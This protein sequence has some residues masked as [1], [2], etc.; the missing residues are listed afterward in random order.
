MRSIRVSI[1]RGGTFTDVYAEMTTPNG[2]DVQVIK[3]LSEDPA[4]YP[5]A[6]REGIRR[7]LELF[8]GV[9]H[10]RGQPVDTSRLEYIRMGT[11][12][13]TN[14]LLE[15]NG[16]RTALVITKGFKD[17]LYIGNQSRPKIFD[18]EITTPDML[19]EDVVEVSER[20]QLVYG[21]ARE[22]TDIQGISGDYVRVLEPP[23]VTEL[24]QQLQA[25]RTKGI[26]SIA[27]V[28]T[29]SYTFPRH[30]QAI[31]AI[32]KELGFTQISLS[33]EIM[34]MIKMVP[35]GFTSCADA[36]LT[37]VI[38]D[39][40][41]SFC[42]GF[43]AGLANVKISFMQ[44]DGGL[45]PMASFCGN[46]AILS[47]PAGG[48]V[49]YAR[50]T[51]PPTHG[52]HAQSSL[53]VIGFDMGG[54][55]TD[56]S[57]FDGN[58]DHVFESVTAN[59]PIRAPQLDIQTVAAGGGSRLFYKNNMFV[60]GPESVRAHPGPVCYRKNGYLSVTDANL[61]TGRILPKY[62]P[63]I[64]GPH[65]N[66]PLDLDGAR[67]AFEALTA[68]INASQSVTYSVEEVA[69]GFLR[70]ANEAMC[71]PIR[72]LTQMRGYDIST[73][74]L[75]CFGGAGP[76]HACAIAKALGMTK[77]YVQRYSGIL[78][79]YG[80]SLAD[81][82]I[83]KQLPASS[84]YSA[85]AKPSVV[86]NLL[87]LANV[88]RSDLKAEGFDEAFC[89]L[90]YYLNLRYE[91]TDTALMTRCLVTNP[92]A[93]ITQS[94][95][96]FDFEAAF[97]EKYQQ[98]FGFLL[99][100][101]AILIDDIRVRGT[102]S[103]PS[104]KANDDARAS[105]SAAIAAPH[106]TTPLYFDDAKLWKHVPVYRHSDMLG[107]ATHLLGPA[108]IM[109]NQATVVVE[110]DWHAEI[111]P[112]GDLYLYLGDQ[113]ESA[114]DALDLRHVPVVMDPIQLSVFSHRFMG[115][116][117]QMGRT[118][119]RTSVSVNIKERLDFSCALFGPDGGLVANAP[120]LPVHLGAMQQAVRF[121]MEY[122]GENIREGDVLV[123]NHPQ[124]AGGSHLP[125]I[126][127]MT[128]VFEHGKIV[129]FV[130]SRGHHADIGGIAPGSMPPLSKCLA[131]EGAAIVAFK[132]VD[133][134]DGQFQEAGITDILLQKGKVD[135]L[136]RPA[137]GTR[138]LRDNLS[139]LK[140]QVAA[141]QKGVHL[142][143]DLIREYTLR[144]VTAYMTFIQE[145]AE[146]AVRTMLHE[147]SLAQ[148]L[149]EVGSV[150]AEDFMDDGT[151]LALQITIDR[152]NDSAIFDFT[153]TGAEVFGNINAPPAVTYSAIIYCLRCLLIGDDL[154][155]NQGCL[156]PIQVIFPKDG[157]ILN[158]SSTAAVV[159]GNVLTSQRV[160]DVIFLA[161]RAAAASQG[162]MN[163]LTFGSDTLGGYYET[164][165]GGAGA[166]PHWH[167]RSGVHT[168]MTNTRI[169][170][171]EILEKRFPVLLESFGLRPG[172]GGRGHFNGGDGVV[173]AL[174]F[175]EPMTVSILSERRAFQPYGLEG[176]EPGARGQNLLRYP[177]GRQVNLGG[178]NTV[179]VTPGDVLTIRSPGGG[180]YGPSA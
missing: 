38:K 170:D 37:P 52:H 69:S 26:K 9:P 10:P 93:P 160:T 18:L 16:E 162:C 74:V 30:E 147:F 97:L 112:N 45:T 85:A 21:N 98:E 73:H 164:I 60:V 179:Q 131:E 47:G 180:G 50:T 138:N 140:A 86:A 175:L 72:N 27:V 148:G 24:R 102:F 174:K 87:E 75:A 13:A 33:S 62:F 80:L 20:V 90:D 141:N 68:E 161:F 144:V 103:P 14:A 114:D 1:D 108:V 172:S 126:T 12:V 158:P 149:P 136:G 134:R 153:G 159:G 83:D 82:V 71:R 129:F 39:Y 17:L 107:T 58:F 36:Y 117:E 121:Q 43:D 154:P 79:A 128:P 41:A 40:L 166:G 7:I 99:S 101:R 143:Q 169:T 94:L 157:S 135:S 104:N 156:T 48:V 118:L 70:V 42:S 57:R 167:G 35:R 150:A 61:V 115:I 125:D 146:Q 2:I 132:L 120:H 67:K 77:V 177:D 32:A 8:T 145:T 28:L 3:L 168:H 91:G 64:F 19:Y 34:P 29:H 88:V 173:R 65:E 116:A 171:P 31:G 111:L 124:L 137:I 54:T 155:L 152:R 163:N 76:Q 142:M 53:P 78:S 110:N 81:S 122:W 133:G 130:A 56:V 92:L 55:S 165:A 11:T 96:A 25:L 4:N 109:Q 100:Q 127:V 139:D 5:D 59:V 22:A 178:K 66:E 95:Q 176:G 106:A 44:S 119:A 63:H 123:S 15:R 105:A 23:N 151:R 6:P 51:R 89:T 113:Q 84:T 46:R 49:G